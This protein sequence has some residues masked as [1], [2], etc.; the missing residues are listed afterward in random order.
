MVNNHGDGV[1]PQDLGVVGPLP[2]GHS[3][4]VRRSTLTMLEFNKKGVQEIQGMWQDTWRIIPFS[5][6]LITM[7]SKSPKWDYSPYKWPKWLIYWG[8][9]LLT[10]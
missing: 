6:W 1:R 10:N 5:K 3:W 7:V 4:A 8:Y 2:N 9:Y